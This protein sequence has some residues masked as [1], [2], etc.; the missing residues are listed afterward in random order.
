[1]SGLNP[2]IISK[3][4][5]DVDIKRF[6][7]ELE[8]DPT[9]IEKANAYWDACGNYFRGDVR[10]GLYVIA[11]FRKCALYSQEGVLA[12][13]RAYRELLDLS[14]EPPRRNSF[15]DKLFTSVKEAI[16]LLDGRD[17]QDVQWLLNCIK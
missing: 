17:R 11:A 2:K 16:N 7:D 5:K 12:L 1:M 15:D 6:W 13:A 10:S 4:W 8:A 3:K 14:G 9:N